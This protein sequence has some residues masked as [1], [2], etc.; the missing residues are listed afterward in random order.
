M[1]KKR[2]LNIPLGEAITSLVS[3][4]VHKPGKYVIPDQFVGVEHE[5]EID[6]NYWRGKHPKIRGWQSV[7]DGSLREGTEYI[8]DGAAVGTEIDNRLAEF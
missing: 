5:V 3:P 6:R 8:F 2:S 4:R 7:K 1:L